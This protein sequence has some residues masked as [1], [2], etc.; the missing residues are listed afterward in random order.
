MFA[1]QKYDNEGSNIRYY[2]L[3]TEDFPYWLCWTTEDVASFATEQEAQH[4]LDNLYRQK[5]YKGN[6]SIVSYDTALFKMKYINAPST[7]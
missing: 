6:Y 5:S 2:Y 3:S 4:K 7:D 1:I